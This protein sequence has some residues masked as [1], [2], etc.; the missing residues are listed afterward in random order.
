M[1]N[2]SLTSFSSSAN[3]SSTASL[4]HSPNRT[5]PSLLFSLPSSH[6][7]LTIQTDS[8]PSLL[9]SFSST[10]LFTL[11]H[12]LLLNLSLYLRLLL[13]LNSITS[14]TSTNT[15][16]HFHLLLL[17]HHQTPNTSALWLKSWIM[18][19]TTLHH[20]S[21]SSSLLHSWISHWCLLLC[22]YRFTN[23]FSTEHTYWYPTIPQPPACSFVQWLTSYTNKKK[24]SVPFSKYFRSSLRRGH[25]N[26]LC[27][28]PILADDRGKPRFR[29]MYFSSAAYIVSKA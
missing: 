15:H 28:V 18:E 29:I 2:P 10:V 27:I 11:M 26:L 8:L 4:T 22:I 13:L 14:S 3:S 24:N 17:L 12:S 7:S 16:Y 20:L 5:L 21:H 23:H 6:G 1:L 25:A 9:L 19:Q